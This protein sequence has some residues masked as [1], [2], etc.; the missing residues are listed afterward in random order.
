MCAVD[1]NSHVKDLNASALQERQSLP[2]PSF[3][4]WPS[5]PRFECELIICTENVQ[6]RFLSLNIHTLKRWLLCRVSPCQNVL[7]Q[8]PI[9]IIPIFLFLCMYAYPLANNKHA[10][11][12]RPD[13]FSFWEPSPH[14]PEFFCLIMC[15]S[16]LSSCSTKIK[17]ISQVMQECSIY[18]SN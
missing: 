6:S 15:F 16:F 12:S 13:S 14:I 17:S 1:M 7:N 3:R 5:L 18:Y 4:A 2:S 9:T 10:K 8:Y 11:L